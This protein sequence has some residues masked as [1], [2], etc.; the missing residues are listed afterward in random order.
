V[1][2]SNQLVVFTLDEY[3]IAL[4]L[5]AVE[6][7]VHIVEI[8]PL[9]KAPDIV[10]GVFNME[11]RIIPVLNIRKRFRL[12]E[13]EMKL[14]DQLIVANTSRQTV[15]LVAD[16]VSSVI[17]RSDQEIVSA[18]KIFPGMEYVKGVVK[19]EDGMILIHDI[20][21]FLSLGEEKAI[22]K[23]MK[24]NEAQGKTKL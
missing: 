11:G 23:A 17:E 5:S 22:N 6:R 7:V 18:E 24:Y 12:P 2:K 16:E 21:K 19:L 4:Y 14:S 13:R 1:N 8:T 9:P 3:R 15:A 10:I 20:D